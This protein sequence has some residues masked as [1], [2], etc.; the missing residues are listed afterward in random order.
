MLLK[1]HSTW[2]NTVMCWTVKTLK[3]EALNPIS[4]N[5]SPILPNLLLGQL[6]GREVKDVN[7]SN[8]EMY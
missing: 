3:Q 1:Q 6:K 5:Q 8:I 4:N 7:T 2:G